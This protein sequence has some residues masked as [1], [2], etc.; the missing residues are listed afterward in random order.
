[1]QQAFA[2]GDPLRDEIEESRLLYMLLKAD[3]N[4]GAMLL[5]LCEMGTSS[6]KAVESLLGKLK[7]M[8]ALEEAQVA[9][10]SLFL[11]QFLLGNMKNCL[12]S[13]YVKRLKEQKLGFQVFLLL[14]TEL[15]KAYK[16]LVSNPFLVF[17]NMLMDKRL[18]EARILLQ[19][20]RVMDSESNEKDAVSDTID[21][22]VTV[23]AK[24]ALRG[25]KEE[26]ENNAGEASHETVESGPSARLRVGDDGWNARVRAEYAYNGTPDVNLASAILDLGINRINVGV[27]CV[28]F[29]RELSYGL[30]EKSFKGIET[31]D[32][33]LRV[34]SYAKAVLQRENNCDNEAG[35]KRMEALMSCESFISGA[36]LFETLVRSHCAYGLSLTDILQ[37]VKARWLRDKLIESDM[38]TLAIDVATRCNLSAG[39]VWEHWG[40]AML[41]MGNYQDAREKFRHCLK[42]FKRRGVID[43]DSDPQELLS[44]IIDVNIIFLQL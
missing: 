38:L 14:P 41:S 44:R 17:E 18:S 16:P 21:S 32:V 28:D 29:C 27:V 23:Y 25:F 4:S 22:I 7:S 33:I 9:K 42:S 30:T 37:P 24:K 8:D 2:L 6:V 35:K 43:D 3:F 19:D 5:A 1:M 10:A 31:A 36:E 40:F 11:V 15:Q 34:L 26:D 20:L 13:D 12:D 39:K